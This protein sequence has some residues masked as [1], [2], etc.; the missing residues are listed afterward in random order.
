LAHALFFIINQLNPTFFP[1]QTN[2]Q[3]KVRIPVAEVAGV[4]RALVD[5][6]EAWADVAGRYP[7]VAKAA[8]EDGE[9]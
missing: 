9:A 5:G 2:N 4:I 6:A 8:A 1:Q 3:T 7:A